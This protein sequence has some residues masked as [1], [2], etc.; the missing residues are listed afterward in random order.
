MVGRD[1]VWEGLLY[2]AQSRHHPVGKEEPLKSFEQKHGTISVVAKEYLPGIF[3]MA[4]LKGC[5]FFF[6]RVV[7]KGIEEWE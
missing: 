2:P 7:L 3:P 4:S 6:L 1:H 5:I